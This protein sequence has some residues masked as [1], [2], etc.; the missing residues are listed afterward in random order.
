MDGKLVKMAQE[1]DCP[2][3]TNDYNLNRVAELQG[4]KMLNINELANAIKAVVLPGE[5]LRVQI[6]QEGKEIG[7]RRGL[8]G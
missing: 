1:M 4:V 7:P 5:V 2:I 3:L 6:I 8:S